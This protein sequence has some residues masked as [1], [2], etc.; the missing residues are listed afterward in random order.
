MSTSSSDGQG[1]V[2]AAPLTQD[3]GWILAP[4]LE[5]PHV[6]AGVVFSRDG[7]ILGRSSDLLQETGEGMAALTGSALGVARTMVATG[8]SD[9]DAVADLVISTREGGVYY[10]APAGSGSGLVL[11][12]SRGVDMGRLAREVQVQVSKLVQALDEA[13]KSRTPSTPPRS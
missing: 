11:W 1:A 6:T 4:L 10:V 2:F 9:G 8:S 12:A 3:L 5:L 13:S 7:L